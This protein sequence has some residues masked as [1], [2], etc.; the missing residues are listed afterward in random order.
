MTTIIPPDP[1]RAIVKKDG[2]MQEVFRIFVLAVA[3]LSL[4]QGSGSPEGVVEAEV[5]REYMDTAGTASAIKYIKRDDNIG[6][7]KTKG[8]ILI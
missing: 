3:K 8:W 4:L 6:G 5:G 1:A 7:D 2:L